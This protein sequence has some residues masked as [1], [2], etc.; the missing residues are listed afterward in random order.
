MNV[1]QLRT[2]LDQIVT[3]GAP[4]LEDKRARLTA[5]C[6]TYLEHYGENDASLLRAPARINVLGEHID[7]VSYLPTASLTFGSRE[8]DALLLYSRSALPFVRGSSTSPG[9]DPANFPLPEEPALRF[10]EEIV[11]D[12]LAFLTKHGTPEPH[13]Q[14]YI[15]GSVVFARG[16][17]GEQVV[18]GF[19][20]AVDSNIPAGGGA[21]SSSA[22]VVLGGACIRYVNEISFTPQQLARDSALAEW[23]I[24]TR[25]GSM[26]HTTIC[27][28]QQ[29]SAVL[30]NYATHET[31][32]LGIPDSSFAWITFF[33]RPANKGQE[34]MLEYNERAA[35]SRLIIPGIISNWQ[36]SNPDL[37]NSW[38][39]FLTEVR[40]GNMKAIAS[41]EILLESLPQ[42]ISIESLQTEYPELFLEFQRSFTALLRET[43]RW[44][45][46]VRTRAQHHLGEVRRVA[47]AEHALSAIQNEASPQ[48]QLDVMRALGKLINESHASL[49]DLYGVSTDEVEQL[50]K[51]IRSDANVIGARLMGGGFGGNVLV[52]TTRGHSNEL[53]KLVQ[54]KYYRPRGRDGV[55]EGSVMIS[56]PGEGLS[57]I[58]LSGLWREFM[59][60]VNSLG[61]AAAQYINNLRTLLDLLPVTISST[62]IWPVIVA[63]GKGTRAAASGLD[64]PKP[65]ALVGQ[66][67]AIVH[68]LDNI[69]A[70]LGP[71]LPPVVIVSTETEEQCREQ[72]RDRE[73]IFVKQ[74][75]SLGT[76][77][78]VLCAK[79][80]MKDFDGLSL[81]AWSTQPVIRPTTF[82]LTAK[83][84][85][86]FDSYEMIVPTT[87]R[88]SPYAPVKRSEFGEVQTARETHLESAEPVEFGETNIGMFMLKNQTMFAR[89]QELRDR[90]WSDANQRYDRSRGELGFPNELIN[91]L[92]QHPNGVFAGP[93]SDWR[94]EQGIKQLSDIAKCELFIS[95][96]AKDDARTIG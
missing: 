10:G 76:G 88:K 30:I 72:L 79:E 24:G 14:N 16:K 59:V 28:A 81:V 56:T 47:L 41:G 96:L 40:S 54:E 68:V 85:G 44:P 42:S 92:A 52:L 5:L 1:S 23:F 61:T 66:K 62:N 3:E 20:F 48:A 22:L 35:V 29:S 84:A 78:A 64:V 73:V 18:N 4:N 89:L 91:S 55:A 63:A 51:T 60:H 93:I 95:E 67:P 87:F 74:S 69:R 38:N 11:A 19:D 25:G 82:K 71:T 9:Y 43:D 17:Y 45:L 53:I 7:Y 77:D 34:V 70:G 36:K 32:R 86:L 26:D 50:I 58:D 75:E 12:W 49:R 6:N 80:V 13:W 31:R 39:K 37:Y 8:R 90:H 65:L 2:A 27:L 21:S 94:E 15:Q 83:L 46:A 57:Q 33:S